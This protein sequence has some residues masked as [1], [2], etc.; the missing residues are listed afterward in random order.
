MVA[1]AFAEPITFPAVGAALEVEHISHAFDIDGSVLPV[2]DDVNFSV[3]PGEFI[4][5]LGP[6]GCGKSTLLRLVAGLE[7]P[8]SGSLREDGEA[9]SGPFPSRVVVF[10]DPTLFPWRTVW[11]NVALG[12]EAQGILK[13]QRQRV[14]DAIELVGPLAIR[15]SRIAHKAE[16][17]GEHIAS[18]GVPFHAGDQLKWCARQRKLRRA[19]P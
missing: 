7:L 2:L 9:I 13:G 11:N 14:D 5:L 10:Q 17:E 8:R 4:A 12:L 18:R 3:K 1:H 19:A 16:F 15:D 6:S